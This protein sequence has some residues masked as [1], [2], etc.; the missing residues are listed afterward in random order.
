[1]TE[2]RKY[3]FRKALRRYWAAF[4]G[5]GLFLIGGIAFL[6]VGFEMTGWSLIDWLKSPYA[7]TCG[8]MLSG[9]LV[10]LVWGIVTAKRHRLGE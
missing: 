10:A 6:L 5:S 9:A 7:V 8:I 3:R 4:L 2:Y 1:M